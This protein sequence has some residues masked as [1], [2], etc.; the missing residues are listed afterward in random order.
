MKSK[1]TQSIKSPKTI[2]RTIVR[3]QAVHLDA[4]NVIVGIVAVS[5]I[6]D[7]GKTFYAQYQRNQKKEEDTD[8][9]L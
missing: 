7:V 8:E 3:P 9:E 5:V 4:T 6:V 2:Q 1:L